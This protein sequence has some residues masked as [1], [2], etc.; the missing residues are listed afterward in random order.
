MLGNFQSESLLYRFSQK[1][2]MHIWKL[3]KV[4]KNKHPES[5]HSKWSLLAVWWISF[6]FCEYI[7]VGI[8]SRTRL[9]FF[10]KFNYNYVV[11]AFS[12]PAFSHGQ[13]HSLGWCCVLLHNCITSLSGFTVSV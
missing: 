13:K 1:L 12:Y 5:H 6:K 9:L 11:A 10:L 8:R 7:H 4:E 2:F 3:R